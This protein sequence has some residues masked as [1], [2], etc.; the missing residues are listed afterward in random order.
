MPAL[1]SH[2]QATQAVTTDG[3]R[4]RRWWW[5][6]GHST[7]KQQQQ[8]QRRFKARRRRGKLGAASGLSM[9]AH[10]AQRTTERVVDP[11]FLC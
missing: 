8:Q 3:R 1:N 9:R 6:R 4:R 10:A 11:L 5:R 7:R 2:V